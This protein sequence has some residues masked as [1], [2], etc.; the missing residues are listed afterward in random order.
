MFAART[1]TGRATRRPSAPT[2]A[3]P[4]VETAPLGNILTTKV[5]N[6]PSQY[7]AENHTFASKAY[8]YKIDLRYKRSE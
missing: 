4:R 8:L 7:L 3:V 1:G 6:R 5:T 2:K